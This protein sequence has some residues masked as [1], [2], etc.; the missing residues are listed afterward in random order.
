MFYVYVLRSDAGK[1]YIGYSSDLRRRMKE[2]QS[3]RVLTTKSAHYELVYYE[4]YKNKADAVG[5]EVFLK[6]GS[7]HRFLKKQLKHFL[8]EDIHS[9]GIV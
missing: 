2:H 5:R 6:S 4:A 1:F 3:R 9:A 8:E 7:G